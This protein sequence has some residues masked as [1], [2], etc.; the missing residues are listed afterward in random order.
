MANVSKK[1]PPSAHIDDLLGLSTSSAQNEQHSELAPEPE[2][3][4]YAGKGLRV[5]LQAH[6]SPEPSAPTQTIKVTVRFQAIS[7]NEIS[8]LSF[9][10][11][12]PKSQSLRMGAIAA[13]TVLPSSQGESLTMHATLPNN[14]ILR[15]RLRISFTVDGDAIQEQIDFAKFPTNLARPSN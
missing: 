15:L 6:R 3:E 8:A 13:N 10:A 4:A 2:I 7:G 9:Q 5:T 12:V 11:A 1:A 14:A